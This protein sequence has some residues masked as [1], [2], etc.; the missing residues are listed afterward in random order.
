MRIVY[1]PQSTEKLAMIT[2]QT[3]AEVIMEHHGTF[4]FYKEKILA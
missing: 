2:A 3:G 4:S 1:N